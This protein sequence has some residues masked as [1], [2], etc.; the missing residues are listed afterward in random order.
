M[1]LALGIRPDIS[2]AVNRLAQFTQKPQLKHWT[3]IKWVLWYLKGTHDFS[4]TYEGSKEL[5]I[6]DINI[7]WN[8]D[9]AADPDRK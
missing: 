7:F 5:L 2:Y 1:Y 8:A 9:W 4:L 6:Q 3:A